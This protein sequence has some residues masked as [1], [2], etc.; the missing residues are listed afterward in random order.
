[1]NQMMTILPQREL[2][3]VI[4]GA[5]TYIALFVVPLLQPKVKH[6]NEVLST[7]K[8]TYAEAKKAIKGYYPQECWADYGVPDKR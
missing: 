2:F 5:V 1:M 3:L 4:I 6:M 8:T 7:V